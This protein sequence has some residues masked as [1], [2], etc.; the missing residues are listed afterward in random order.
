M[1]T[2]AIENAT[3]YVN[4]SSR[5]A[6]ALGFLSRP[7]LITMPQG[8]HNIEADQIFALIQEYQTRPREQC[9]WEAHRKYIDVQFVQSGVES[10]GWA[11]IQKMRISKPYDAEKDLA[12]FEGAG[13][14]IDISAG[15]F[16]IFMP[17]DVHMPCMAS[18][19]PQQVRKIV[20]KV[21]VE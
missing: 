1:L 7:D 10:M 2:D 6:T 15:R 9:F 11:P 16:I 8:K 21:A 14:V 12:V 18:R 13:Q 19:E 5:I 17:H 3:S 4:L 20:V